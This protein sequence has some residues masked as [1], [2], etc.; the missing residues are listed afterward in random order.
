LGDDVKFVS[1]NEGAAIL[2]GAAL[3]AVLGIMLGGSMRPQLIFDDGRPMGPQMFADGGGTRS[4]GPFDLRD[5]YAAYGGKLPSYVTGT[6]YAQTAYVEEAPIAEEHQQLAHNDAPAPAPPPPL[7]R[8]A[9]DEA[10]AP[11]IVYPS[12][13]GGTSY[14]AETPP[15]PAPPEDEAPVVI[16]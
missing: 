6:D 10:R 9:Y 2:S 1:T 12:V 5:A 7:T 13:S 3:A 15:P 8:A 11:I 16:G 4:T 14:D